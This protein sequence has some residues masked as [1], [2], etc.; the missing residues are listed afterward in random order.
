MARA[1]QERREGWKAKGGVKQWLALSNAV[2]KLNKHRSANI[3]AHSQS[4]RVQ[5]GIK[6]A[7][8]GLFSAGRERILILRVQLMGADTQVWVI[9]S[10]QLYKQL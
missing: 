2:Q 10:L 5:G 7:I 1:G 3:T 9:T 6:Y 8:A 4:K